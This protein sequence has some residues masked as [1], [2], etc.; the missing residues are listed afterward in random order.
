MKSTENPKFD[1]LNAISVMSKKLAN[2]KLKVKRTQEFTKAEEQLNA[3]FDTT[4]GGT[5]MLCAM[6]SYYF[7]HNGEVCNFNDLSV[8]FGC[9]VMN[10]I[11]YKK[12]IDKLLKIRYIRN[13]RTAIDDEIGLQNQFEIS[14]ELLRAVL[15]NKKIKLPENEADKKKHF[16]D[17]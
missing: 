9:P 13:T 6:I 17:D 10:T 1:V 15:S 4:S 16:N 2:S 12:D 7:D 5:W 3:Y 14:S 8:F 11:A